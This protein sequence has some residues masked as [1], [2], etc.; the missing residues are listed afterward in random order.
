MDSGGDSEQTDNALEGGRTVESEVT[1][2]EE[3]KQNRECANGDSET[4]KAANGVI[5]METGGQQAS[6][7]GNSTGNQSDS[8]DVSGTTEGESEENGVWI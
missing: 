5:V 1:V 7:S 8:Q 4:H 6:L 2:I 3:N